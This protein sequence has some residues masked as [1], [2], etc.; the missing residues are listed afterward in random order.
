MKYSFY[1]IASFATK[2]FVRN[3]GLS[4][5]TVVI[6]LL[7]L[8]SINTLLSVKHITSA[9][10]KAVEAQV[11][12][13]LQFYPS[14]DAKLVEEVIKTVQSFPEVEEATLKSADDVRNDFRT[15]HSGEKDIVNAL[16]ALNVNPF[17]AALV[18]K[19][20]KSEDYEKILTLINSDKYNKV[21]EQKTF[22]DHEAYVKSIT[23]ITK[24]VTQVATTASV[25]LVVFAFFIIFN[26]IRV[27]MY[28]QREEIGIMRLVGASKW[29][30]RAPFYLESVYYSAL[31]VGASLFLTL[32]VANMLDP[33]IRQNFSSTG[34]SLYSELMH[35][36]PVLIFWEFFGVLGLSILSASIA[37]RKYLAV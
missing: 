24:R 7:A 28:S 8:L 22:G 12:V 18:I 15:R 10:L 14:A 26:A 4:L 5:V 29:F 37:M 31:A 1:R 36:L 35:E 16:D 13:R 30:I 33:F 19:A 27:T 23:N 34:F 2:N 3:I 21:I 17:G 25:I 20:H 9:S 32:L 6:L 11:D